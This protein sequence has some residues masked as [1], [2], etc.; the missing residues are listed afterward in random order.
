MPY[1]EAFV[2]EV[3]RIIGLVLVGIVRMASKDTKIGSFLVPKGTRIFPFIYHIMRDPSYWGPDAEDF[4]PEHFLDAYEKKKN[5]DYWV[6]FG[7]GRRMCVAKYLAMNQVKVKTFL[8]N[9]IKE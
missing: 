6:P 3:Q 1:T 5:F 4:K 7:M 9:A 8:L 2:D